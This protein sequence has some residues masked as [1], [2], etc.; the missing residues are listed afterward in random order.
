MNIF[1]KLYYFFE[2]KKV[3]FVALLI[4]MLVGLLSI[5]SQLNLEEDITKLIPKSEKT[6]TLNKVLKNTNFSDKIVINI[7][8]ASEGN[9]D[10]LTAYASEMVDSLQHSCR[11]YILSIQGQIPDDD[12]TYTLDF[13]YNNLP[14]FLEEVDY[15]YL[16]GKL[17]KD[18]IAAL[19]ESNF[20]TLI[21][22][23]GLIAK[24]LIRKDPFG[25]S[26]RGLKKL[27]AL[28]ISDDFEMYN[29]Y[30]LTNNKQNL[31]LF[32]NPALPTNDTDANKEFVEKL[33]SI[34]LSLNSKYQTKA[35]S[36]YYG[37]TVI[38]ASN[39]SQIKTDIQ[40]TVSIALSILLL[41]L[42]LF[43]KRITIPILLFVPTALGALTAIA[44]LHFIR[45]SISAISLGI[46]SILLGITLDYSLHILTHYRNNNDV[47]QLYKDVTK[48]I[49]MSSITTAVAFLCLLLLK[50]QA[51]QDLGIF[52]AISVVST[53]LF[54]LVIIPLLYKPKAI[55]TSDSKNIIERI[56]RYQFSKNR[57]LLAALG[58][59]LVV[60]FFTSKKV[61]FN[62]D[63]NN[64][65][66]QSEEI[67]KAQNNLDDLLKLSSKSV[68]VV[69]YGDDL[70]L[71]LEA[72]TMINDA[73]EIEQT[74]NQIL[75]YSSNGAIVLS[76]K[77][78][79][80]KINQWNSFFTTD[81]KSTLKSDLIEQGKEVGFKASTYQTFYNLLDK[82][83]MP[84]GLEEYAAVNAFLTD[85][86][87]TDN[88]ELKTVVTLVKL[89]EG[90]KVALESVIEK[91]PNT[92]LIDRKA[93][94]ETFLG[95]LRADFSNLV[96]YSFIAVFLIIL[97][98][99][100]NIELTLL[101][102]I[103]IAITWFLTLGVMGVFGIEFTIFNVIISTFIFGL[104]VDY[105]IFITNGLIKD[106]TKGT[107]EITTYKVSIILSV[108]TTIL[109]VGVLIFA[110]H[111]AL[112]SISALCL[113]GI[114][115]TLIVSF[116]IQPLLFRIFV[117]GRAK[118]G[119]SPIKLRVFITSIISLIVYGMGG[120]L[121]S[122][123]SIT[124]LQLIP[125][126]KKK[127]NKWLHKN[128]ARLVRWVLYS[129]P[130][131]KKR[132]VN[133]VNE[134]FDKPAIIIS[135]HSS[136]LDTLTMGLLTHKVIYLV[137]DWVYKSPIFG[138]L[139]RVLGFYPVSD[140]VDNSTEH[141][142]SKVNEGYSLVIFPEAKRSLS[143]KIGRFHKGAFYLQQQLKI[144][145]LPIYT[146][147]NS[148]VMPKNDF[149][150][151]DGNLTVTVGERIKHDD[152]NFG[153][154][155]R[156][157]TK[158]ISKYYKNEFLKLRGIYEDENY[159][160]RILVSNY[161][162]KEGK[163]FD[164]VKS[165]FELYKSQYQKLNQLISIKCKL[166]HICNDLGQ[167]DILLVSKSKDRIIISFIE[168]E[169]K[170]T[171]AE[172]CYVN[173]H[174]KVD[175][176]NNIDAKDFSEIDTLLISTLK[177]IENLKHLN[178]EVFKTVILFNKENQRIKTLNNGSNRPTNY[179]EIQAHSIWKN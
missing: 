70:N 63:L 5:S 163:L 25:L 120:I 54:A 111:P 32:L 2:H 104:G 28:K 86:F 153:T 115:I 76:A 31:L 135:N 159:F 62:K 19:V 51:L 106:Y 45:E 17:S 116:T 142:Q 3:V 41:I 177:G 24:K 105:S 145:I 118:K 49:L 40:F 61:F 140:G 174:K 48:P 134:T 83:F 13:M 148:E 67:L 97:V 113:I 131:V 20:K 146:H 16:E 80:E 114:S 176:I 164:K 84:I 8:I 15:Q 133:T 72:N 144:D 14:L 11:E 138:I 93:I 46:G 59:L 156:E 52:A 71:V 87:I 99:F 74:K 166:L 21:S 10:D 89:N 160:K 130:F 154:S 58:L 44:S 36:E 7:A 73:L 119:F 50:S 18:S 169:S 92:L 88:K 132:V 108:I 150:I 178:L 57:I 82:K 175:F 158:K 127:K 129:N 75:Q 157:R 137:N 179:K 6:K 124:I 55:K 22:P 147:G 110:K 141:L 29:G 168:D 90:Q 125:I 96:K 165:D 34:S 66:Y 122:L 149:M 152:E 30:L 64:M 4:L 167:L 112:R 172:N 98:F 85:E 35:K 91:I 27:E 95:G 103:P 102:T 162:H 173:R 170:R 155:D 37:S 42:I 143:N 38:A 94:S 101:T 53:S 78:Q 47:K 136:S 9:P 121:L 69:A 12:I 128:S 60:S 68:Y 43:Y 56:A 107:K 26:F 123:F 65:N 117:S 100:K 171:I 39:A 79:Q 139:A 77:S 126:L 161:L 109:G 81:V 1:N 33:Y 151:H 23:S